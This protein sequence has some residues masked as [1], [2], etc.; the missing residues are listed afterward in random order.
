VL[1]DITGVTGLAISRAIVAG[2]RDPVHLVRCREPQCASRPEGIAKAWTGHEQPA[3]V[4]ALTQALARSE[5]DTEPVRER[6][7]A[8]ERRFQALPPVGPGAL[9]PLHRANTSR[10]HPTNALVY[11]ARGWRYPR[12][13]VDL[14]ALPGVNAS[15]VHTRLSAIGLDRRQ[16]PHAKAFCAWLGLAPHDAIAGGKSWRRST[17]KTRNRVGQHQA[18]LGGHG[19]DG[20]VGPRH[21][22]RPGRG[23]GGPG[24]DGGVG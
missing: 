23:P 10:T 17:L 6:E 20:G 12:T 13:G 1:T 11:D 2:E 21:R 8:S 7:A 9:P 19:H 5:A 24:H 3:P 18:G 4:C 15:P 22:G 14:G 16:W